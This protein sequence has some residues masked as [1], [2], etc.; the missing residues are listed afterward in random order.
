MSKVMNGSEFYPMSARIADTVRVHGFSWSY[1][2]YVRQHGFAAWEFFI[3]AGVPSG[4]Q[5]T[6]WA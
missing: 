4:L 6:V 1:D 2:Y 3:L 5:F